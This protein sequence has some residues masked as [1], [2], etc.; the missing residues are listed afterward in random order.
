MANLLGEGSVSHRWA[1]AR[2]MTPKAIARR[3]A[4]NDRSP[5]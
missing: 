4:K 2:T 3:V 1:D 5:Y